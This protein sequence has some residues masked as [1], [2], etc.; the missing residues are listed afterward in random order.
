MKKLLFVGA[1]AATAFVQAQPSQAYFR[2]TWCAKIEVDS[3][4]YQERCDFPT[5]ATCRGYITSQPR[6]FCVQNQWQASNWG[7]RDNE[8]E[9]RFN[10]RYR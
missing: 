10:W 8:T 1:L 4:T 9:E 6:S 2:G 3:G 5:F 7:V